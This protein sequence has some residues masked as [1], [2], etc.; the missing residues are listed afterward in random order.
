MF[1]RSQAQIFSGYVF[2]L[3]LLNEVGLGQSFCGVLRSCLCVFKSSIVSFSIHFSQQREGP[4]AQCLPTCCLSV[5]YML[6]ICGHGGELYALTLASVSDKQSMN[7][8]IP[9]KIS[10]INNLHVS[11][12]ELALNHCCAVQ[13]RLAYVLPQACPLSCHQ[14]LPILQPLS[15]C[16]FQTALQAFGG[17]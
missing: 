7:T 8:A 17:F 1:P 9:R 10:Q 14:G 16:L 15:S 4:P 5:L 12:E 6:A 13:P 3:L 2:S 11:T